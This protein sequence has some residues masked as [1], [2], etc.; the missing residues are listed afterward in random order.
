MGEVRLEIE[1]L[2]RKYPSVDLA[3]GFAVESYDIA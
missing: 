1:E 3:N 2:A